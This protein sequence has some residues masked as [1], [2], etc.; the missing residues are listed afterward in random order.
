[1]STLVSKLWFADGWNA[2]QI[3]LGGTL[4]IITIS[5]YVRFLVSVRVIVQVLEFVIF[6]TAGSMPIA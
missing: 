2:G 3:G 1:M 5:L 4:A 6:S